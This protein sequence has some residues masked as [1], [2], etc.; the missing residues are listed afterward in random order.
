MSGFQWVIAVALCLVAI[1]LFSIASAVR[2]VSFVIAEVVTG[3]VT[4]IR[5]KPISVKSVTKEDVDEE[6]GELHIP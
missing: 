5:A 2:R 1:A 3:L 6:E 4:N